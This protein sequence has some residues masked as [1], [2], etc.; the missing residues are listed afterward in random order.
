MIGRRPAFLRD[1]ATVPAAVVFD[2]DGL[3]LDTEAAWTRAEV[4]LWERY[5]L[6]FTLDHKR[7]LIGSSR[8]VAEVKLSEMLARPPAEGAHLMDQLTELTMEELLRG[9]EPRPGAVELLDALVARGTPVGLA[10]NSPRAFMERALGSSPI[11][12]ER[13]GVTL[14]A[15]EVAHAKPAPDVYLAC[16][17]ALHADPRD[18]VAL[19]DSPSGVRAAAAAGMTVVGVPYLDGIDLPEAHVLACS[20]AD[21]EVR[22]ACGL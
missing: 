4:A 22:S 13:F 8:A 12:L 5:G 2:N 9:V 20:L 3:L 21:R 14:S 18:S 19:E 17:A 7:Y 16:C 11:G 6:T 10:S 1:S 15:D